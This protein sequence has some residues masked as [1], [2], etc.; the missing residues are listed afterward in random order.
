M[1]FL[2]PDPHFKEKNHRRCVIIPHFLG[3]YAYVLGVGKIIYTITDVEEVGE[4]EGLFGE[5]RYV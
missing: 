4:D 5:A 1:F 3:E 2:F